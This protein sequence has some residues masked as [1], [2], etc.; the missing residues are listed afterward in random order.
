MSG[1]VNCGVLR[2]DFVGVGITK[3]CHMC[4]LNDGWVGKTVSPNRLC[5]SEYIHPVMSYSSVNSSGKSVS[6][7]AGGVMRFWFSV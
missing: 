7:A 1:G 5:K 4:A 3:F 2:F 6:V